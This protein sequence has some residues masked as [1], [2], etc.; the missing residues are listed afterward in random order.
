MLTR[1]SLAFLLLLIAAHP[2]SAELSGEDVLKRPATE[3]EAALP[4]SHPAFCT[5][6][7]ARLF[8]EG[9]KDDAVKWY[10]VGRI[11]SRLYLK[12][13]PGMPEDSDPAFMSSLD[14]LVN[15]KIIDYAAGNP[16]EWANAIDSALEWDKGH[17]NLMTPVADHHR[18]WE[19][20]RTKFSEF[21]RALRENATAIRQSRSAKGL[22]SR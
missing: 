8:K 12:V 21:S 9:K 17:G 3:V 15:R 16:V 7:A 2:A 11:R 6:Y 4:D 10:Y 22:P 5:L 18:A 19:E 14:G 1:H 20:T 13:N